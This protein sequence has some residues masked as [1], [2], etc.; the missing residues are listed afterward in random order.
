MAQRDD[1][2]S[3]GPVGHDPLRRSLLLGGGL[4]AGAAFAGVAAAQERTDTDPRVLDG[5]PMPEPPEDK[6]AGPVK[7]R[8]RLHAHRQVAVVT[9]AARGIGRAIAVE[10]AANGAD[11]VVIDIAGPVSPA[12]NA[13]PATPEDLA[14]DRAA[15]QSIWPTRRRDPRRYP[16]H[17]SVAR[18]GGPSGARLR[19][20]RHRGGGR[21]D[22][23]LEAAARDG[24]RRLARRDRQQPQR[25]GQ[26][27]PRLR[28]EDG[29]ATSRAD[30][31]AVVHA[32]QARH[33]GCG[34]LLGVQ[35]GHSRLDEVGG[36]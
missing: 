12:S 8:A 34:E 16:R 1:R 14:R 23:A 18:G 6:S 13:K 15:D 24:R 32:G 3:G 29:A 5:Q 11:V 7:A 30:H 17:R 33:Q 27:H 19:Q 25:H 31:R 21:G 28:A 22:P 2:R 26:H 20:D 4:A 36:A 35:M 10:F 9:G